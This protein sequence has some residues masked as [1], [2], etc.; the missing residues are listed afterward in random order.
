MTV[1]LTIIV[2]F[3]RYKINKPSVKQW[4]VRFIPFYACFYV[5]MP[6]VFIPDHTKV[7]FFSK[8]QEHMLYHIL[9]H[10]NAR[11][12]R[13]KNNKH[14]RDYNVIVFVIIINIYRPI[15]FRKTV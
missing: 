3:V 11:V 2:T 12:I 7:S 15:N 6:I 5:Y 1:H 8:K 14:V 10:L 4:L 9:S 13:R